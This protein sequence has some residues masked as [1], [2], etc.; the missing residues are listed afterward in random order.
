M[1]VSKENVRRF[2]LF[3]RRPLNRVNRINSWVMSGVSTAQQQHPAHRLKRLPMEFGN[4]STLFKLPCEISHRVQFE[5]VAAFL[6][7]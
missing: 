5:P 3:V 6:Y 2:T 1:V 4:C 7:L